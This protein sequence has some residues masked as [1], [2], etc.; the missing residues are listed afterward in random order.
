MGCFKYFMGT[1]MSNVVAP[2]VPS[3]WGLALPGVE[4]REDINLHSILTAF[5]TP[6]PRELASSYSLPLTCIEIVECLLFY[7]LSRSFYR[8]QEQ[9][10]QDGYHS[11]AISQES[12]KKSLKR[13]NCPR[14]MACID[15]HLSGPW[16]TTAGSEVTFL[17]WPPLGQVLMA[18]K[19]TQPM[20]TECEE[21]SM[22]QP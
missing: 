17:L 3:Q 13:E 1:K 6:V 4:Y 16:N 10:P 12:C 5:H 2:G 19:S 15:L 20:M 8:T 11:Y 14:T 9:S 18:P 7:L 22:G 21:W